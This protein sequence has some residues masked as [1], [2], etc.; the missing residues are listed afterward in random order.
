MLLLVIKLILAIIVGLF[1]FA[2]L[3]TGLFLLI[4]PGLI[5]RE[6]IYMQRLLNRRQKSRQIFLQLKEALGKYWQCF[7][8]DRLIL[9]LFGL[10]LFSYNCIFLLFEKFY[11][12]LVLSIIYLFINLFAFINWKYNI[13]PN[14]F[15]SPAADGDNSNNDSLHDGEKS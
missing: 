12:G 8:L 15:S 2:I 3:V 9:F 4:N 7:Q 13:L 6:N 10:A 11:F 1:G 5:A 14:D